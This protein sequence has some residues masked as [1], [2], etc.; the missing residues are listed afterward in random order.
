MREVAPGQYAA[1]HFPLVGER[2]DDTEVP[3]ADD[4]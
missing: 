1:C 3:A 4:R 2:A